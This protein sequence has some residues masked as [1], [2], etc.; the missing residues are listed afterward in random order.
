MGQR[1][2]QEKESFLRKRR[3]LGLLPLPGGANSRG[4]PGA[5]RGRHPALEALTT[6]RDIK[7]FLKE[8]VDGRYAFSKLL[9][10]MGFA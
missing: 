2:V 9:K 8:V 7:F 4:P 1:S 10:V 6:Y 5:L 3:F